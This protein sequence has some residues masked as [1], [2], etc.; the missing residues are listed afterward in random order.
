M[1]KKSLRTAIIL[2]WVFLVAYS[3]LK[4][5]PSLANKFVIAVNNERIISAGEFVD[6]HVWLQQIIFGLTTFFDLSF[7][8]VCLCK[9]V[10]INNK[11]VCSVGIGSNTYQYIE[12]L[13]TSRF[14]S[15]QRSNNGN[16]SILVE[17]RLHNIHNHIYNALGRA[18]TN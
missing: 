1:Y 11:T 6:N 13:C 16:I 5:I 3:L 17:K 15:S 2:C 10:E 18:I 9:N 8:F 7:L 14:Y 12:I 4:T